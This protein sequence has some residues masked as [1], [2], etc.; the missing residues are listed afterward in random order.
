MMTSH[1]G[2]NKMRAVDID[3]AVIEQARLRREREQE[4]QTRG[5]EGT[6]FYGT[7]FGRDGR[8]VLVSVP[9]KER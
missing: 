5:R 3:D 4:I 2:A 7:V 6:A 8:K 1:I 9:V